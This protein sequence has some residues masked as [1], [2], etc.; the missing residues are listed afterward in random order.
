MNA[1]TLKK[2]VAA[3]TVALLVSVN[4]A[5]C[6]AHSGIRGALHGRDQERIDSFTGRFLR[7]QANITRADLEDRQKTQIAIE[8]EDEHGGLSHYTVDHVCDYFLCLLEAKHRTTTS[9][10]LAQLDPAMECD[11]VSCDVCFSVPR[12]FSD[13]MRSKLIEYWAARLE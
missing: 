1:D 2:S 3:L 10:I 8:I 12:G 11:E 7:G 13:A 6:A 4:G 5:G 9:K